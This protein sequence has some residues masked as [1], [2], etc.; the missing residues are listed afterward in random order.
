MYLIFFF[1]SHYVQLSR[2]VAWLNLDIYHLPTFHFVLPHRSRVKIV[3]TAVQLKSRWRKCKNKER[4]SLSNTTN[5]RPEIECQKLA[6]KQRDSY[7]NQQ[8]RP[9]RVEVQSK[10]QKNFCRSN[11][12]KLYP[13]SSATTNDK[14]K[15]ENKYWR[16]GGNS[17]RFCGKTL[18]NKNIESTDGIKLMA[19]STW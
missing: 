16:L 2:Y 5:V 17:S 6:L 12:R 15:E 19:R 3:T 14:V 1:S 18:C 10:G 11:T 4:H 13:D 8:Q 7:H 9:Q